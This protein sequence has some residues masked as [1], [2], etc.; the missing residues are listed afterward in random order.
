[1]KL[2][3][4]IFVLLFLLVIL[5]TPAPAQTSPPLKGL[6]GVSVAVLIDARVQ[7]GADLRDAIRQDAEVKL[8]VAGMEIL[9]NGDPLKKPRLTISISSSSTKQFYGLMVE[10]C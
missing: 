6:T 5:P 9:P 2:S 7:A 4:C 10:F 8:R 3:G 1:M